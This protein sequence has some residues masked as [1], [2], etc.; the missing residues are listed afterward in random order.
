MSNNMKSALCYFPYIGV[1][2]GLYILF[3]EKTDK[4][5]RFN[6]IQGLCLI[7]ALDLIVWLLMA[8]LYAIPLIGNIVA[9]LCLLLE[10][11]LFYKTYKGEEV[12]LPLIGPFAKDHA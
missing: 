8:F 7:I 9:V 5:A 11:F 12:I 2:W 4:T 3:T 10:G 6:A 1:F